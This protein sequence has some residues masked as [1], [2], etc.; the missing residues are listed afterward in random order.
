M[1]ENQTINQNLKKMNLKKILKKMNLK[2]RK[3]TQQLHIKEKGLMILKKIIK[4][5]ELILLNLIF[6]LP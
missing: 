2:T 5:L 6:L 3:R 1:L 4:K